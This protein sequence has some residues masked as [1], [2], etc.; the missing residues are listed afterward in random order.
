[1]TG[2]ASNLGAGYVGTDLRGCTARVRMEREACD[3]NHRCET[4]VR[5]LALSVVSS[6]DVV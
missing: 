1:M 5:L 2:A 6:I 4:L 3:T